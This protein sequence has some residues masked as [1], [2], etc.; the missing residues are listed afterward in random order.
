[1]IE[2]KEIEEK[3]NTDQGISKIKKLLYLRRE[4][5]MMVRSR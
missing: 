1:M 2:G 4:S 5:L 3:I